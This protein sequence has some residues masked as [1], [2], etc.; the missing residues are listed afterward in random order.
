MTNQFSSLRPAA[1]RTMRNALLA[2]AASALLAACAAGPS[3]P[4]EIPEGAAVADLYIVDCLLPGQVRQLGNSTYLTPRRPTRTTAQDCRLRGGEYVAFDRADYKTA[5]KVWLPA[6]EAGDAD[7]QNSVG[8]IFER[9]LGT[10][11]NYAVAV[12][13]FERAAKQGHKGAQFN[14]GTLYETGK[15]VPQ[16]KAMALNWYRQ[17]WGLAE[18]QLVYKSDAEEAL[19]AQAEENV[20]LQAEN[21]TLAE[22]MAQARAER[23]KARAEAAAARAEADAAIADA[24]TPAPA[25]A[26]AAPA[27]VTPAEPLVDGGL[28][29]IGADTA[30][31]GAA[32]SK[33]GRD[34]GRYYALVI[35][36]GSYQF[37]DDLQTPASDV[38][39]IARL[40]SDKYGF[41]VQVL[42]NTSDVGVLRALNQLNEVLQEN[43][44][45]LIYYAG[46]GNRRPVGAYEA[47]YWLPV[48]A[49]PPP[50]DTFWVPTEQVSSHLARL[51]ARRIMV[52]TDSTFAGLLAD[53][54]AFLLASGREALLS[55]A[56]IG[57]RFPNKSR[58]LL[59]SGQDFP[60]ASE[61][62]PGTSVFANAFISALQDNEAV[63][64]GPALFLS[65]LDLLDESLPGLDPE[66]KA[67]KRAGD[68][69]GE[70]YFVA[71]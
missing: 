47:G 9:G 24:A 14:L 40:L 54:P 33:D 65:M 26:P 31:P 53:N 10:E 2:A 17:A 45:L 67:I 39:K 16:D 19:M 15:G 11:P 63:I 37:L 56:Y 71:R 69:V 48:N 46:Y 51:P 44:N 49:E 68:E 5:L 1:G 59:T 58:L 62:D 38:D 4:V 22:Q 60:L 29:S 55:D 35:G 57:L 43:D 66:F 30:E 50:N 28:V 8:E 20:A 25:P 27:P 23:E 13:W 12:L 6:A 70:F 34:Y 61:R 42:K 32:V 3:G 52:V 64:T 41:A 18:D 36:N 21:V 7:A